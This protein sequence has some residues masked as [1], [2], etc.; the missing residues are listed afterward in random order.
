MAT[1]LASGIANSVLDALCRSVAWSDPAAFWVKLHTGDP[2]AAGASNAA[3]NTTRQQATFSA[4]SGGAITTSADVTWTSVSTTETYSHVSFWDASTAGTFLG[5][6]A[7]EVA[8]AVTVGDTF[9]IA[10]GDIDLSLT[11]IAA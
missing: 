11:P 8:R 3:T 10:T 9:T 7:L 5:S 1:G 2:G 4:A 6:D